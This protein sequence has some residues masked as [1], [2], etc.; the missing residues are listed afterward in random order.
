MAVLYVTEYA[1]VGVSVAGR[2]QQVPVQPPLQRQ[3]IAI[4][5]SS[6]ALATAFK[7]ATKLVRLHA[8]AICSIAFGASPVATATTERMAANQTEYH[9][10]A[11]LARLGTGSVAVITNT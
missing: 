3:T 6:A 5:G 1:T 2:I 7:T 9:D 8:D 10:V 4:G 11:D